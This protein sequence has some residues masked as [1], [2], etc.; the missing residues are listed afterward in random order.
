MIFLLSKT[1]H[2]TDHQF[3]VT[4]QCFSHFVSDLFIECETRHVYGITNDTEVRVISEQESARF[5]GTGKS[6]TI[7]G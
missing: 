7:K 5:L 3:I 1:S 4:M 6:D 2:V